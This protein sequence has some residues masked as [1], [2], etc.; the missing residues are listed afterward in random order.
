MTTHAAQA[1]RARIRAGWGGFAAN[2]APGFLRAN[3]VILPATY[4]RQFEDFCSANARACPLLGRGAAGQ[5][6]LDE[7]GQDLD[8]RTDV[9]RYD[10]YA[11]GRRT[12]ECADIAGL[13]R[14]DSVAFVLGSWHSNEEA[15]RRAGVPMRPVESG[16]QAGR[17]RTTIRARACGP[18]DGPLVVSMRQFAADDVERVKAVTSV[19]KFAHGAPMHVGDPALLGIADLARPDYGSAAPTRPGEVPMFW[20]SSLTAA[21]AL[22][23]ARAPFAIINAPGWMLVTDIEA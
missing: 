12:G 10:L 21:V 11:I 4:A 1:L 20:A 9:G 19:G 17:Y 15:L 5:A 2:Q 6:L 14:H 18:F 22:E 16:A 7:F 8:V 13:W 3:L 23:T